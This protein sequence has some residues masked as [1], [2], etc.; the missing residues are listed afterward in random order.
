MNQLAKL[1]RYQLAWGIV[2]LVAGLFGLFHARGL[3]FTAAHGA[4]TGLPHY[5]LHWMT[6]N[7]LGALVAI[8]FAVVGIAA[9]V[10]RNPTLA[11]IATVGYLLVALQTLMQWRTGA[12]DNLLGST[13]PTFAF[14]I[15]F[16]LAFGTTTILA[17]ALPTIATHE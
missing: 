16:A 1:Y 3:A 17:R 5:E 12:G 2:G 15:A 8:T 4:E 11:L 14:S 13:G 10:R 6:Y 7:M 9:A